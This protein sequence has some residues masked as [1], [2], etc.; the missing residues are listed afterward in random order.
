[1]SKKGRAPLGPNH[2]AL[3]P[4]RHKRS[5]VWECRVCGYKPNI[6]KQSKFC[7]N[8]GRDFWGNPGSIPEGIT[9]SGT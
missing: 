5:E 4:I 6:D 2:P 8:C 1:M 7:L 3:P 9:R